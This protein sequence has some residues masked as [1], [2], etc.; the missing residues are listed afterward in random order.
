MT[1]KEKIEMEN[2]NKKKIA[3]L[4]QKAN[5]TRFFSIFLA[6]F[7]K[8]ETTFSSQ[9]EREQSMKVSSEKKRELDGKLDSTMA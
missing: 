9:R 8:R 5:K 2:V 1:K 7:H 6:I 3:C 4:I